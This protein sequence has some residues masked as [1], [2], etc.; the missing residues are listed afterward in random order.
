MICQELRGQKLV[1]TQSKSVKHWTLEK[2]GVIRI[3]V[4]NSCRRTNNI[5]VGSGL[6]AEYSTETIVAGM[7]VC[8]QERALN[9]QETTMLYLL[10]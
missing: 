9:G 7:T 5:H 10:Y 6:C 2:C 1:N 3:A 4:F 8:K